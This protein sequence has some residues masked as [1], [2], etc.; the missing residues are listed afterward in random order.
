MKTAI[1]KKDWGYWKAGEVFC[2]AHRGP[3]LLVN[4]EVLKTTRGGGH[5]IG[6]TP[7]G[8][9]VVVLRHACYQIN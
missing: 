2:R 7:E 8:E 6:W 3:I 5:I 9:R 1:I 4:V